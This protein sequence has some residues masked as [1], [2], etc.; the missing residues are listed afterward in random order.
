MRT[1]IGVLLIASAF[2][3]EIVQA[4]DAPYSGLETRNIKALSTEQIDEY[5]QGRGMGLAL[6]AELNGYP[7]PKHVLELKNELVLTST[8]ETSAEEIFEQMQNSAI[9]LGGAIIEQEAALDALFEAGTI[10]K[11]DLQDRLTEIAALKGEL[12]NVHL[13]A[14][15]ETRK[16]LTEEQIDTYILLRGYGGDSSQDHQHHRGHGGS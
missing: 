1:L 3:L 11:Q 14:H 12:R 8:Q 16:L 6:A 4:Q 15:L 9:V 5:R 2:S 13:A 7:G 10:E